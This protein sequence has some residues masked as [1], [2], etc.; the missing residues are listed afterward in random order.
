[1]PGM[2][3][4]FDLIEQFKQDKSIALGSVGGYSEFFVLDP[5]ARKFKGVD[6]LND[7]ASATVLRN[8]FIKEAKAAKNQQNIL[9]QFAEAVAQ[10]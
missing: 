4:D 6:D 1:M 9:N 3:N 5:T 7:N 8:A 2:R 10:D